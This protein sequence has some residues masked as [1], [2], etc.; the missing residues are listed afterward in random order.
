MKPGDMVFIYESG[1]GR[2]EIQTYLDGTSQNIHRRRGAQGIVALVCVTAPSHEL[3]SSKAKRYVDGSAI[4]WRF[5]AP[6][7]SV[8]SAGFIPRQRVA[9]LLGFSIKYPFR[10][11]GD[12]QSGLK[13]ITKCEFEKLH[14]EYVNSA[15]D[16]DTR[17][18]ESVPPPPRGSGGE[19]ATHLALK[20]QIAANPEVVLQEPGL[21]FYKEEWALPSGDRIDLV[22]KDKY[23]RFVVVEVEVD[24]PTTEVVGPLQCLKYRTMLGYLFERPLEEIRSI[25]VAHT[26]PLSLR[27]KIAR[28]AIESVEV[29]RDSKTGP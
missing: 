23:H 3:K 29:P 21:T 10:G 27:Q 25:L 26:I 15:E 7:R 2:A 16:A 24:C 5:H 14:E 13:R 28:Y 19:G 18:R 9:M 12:S 8:N 17:R 4:W 22:L 6:T 20:K 11:F 1:S